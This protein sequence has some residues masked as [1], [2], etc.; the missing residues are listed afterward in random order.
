MAHITLVLSIAAFGAL[1]V[2]VTVA[3]LI[4]APWER[5]CVPRIAMPMSSAEEINTEY[6]VR[7]LP[8]LARFR[9]P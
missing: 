8:P 7:G 4:P 2:A 9:T 5:E 6:L 3:L 1:L